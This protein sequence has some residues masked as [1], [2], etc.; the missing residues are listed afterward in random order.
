MRNKS[1]RILFPFMFIISATWGQSYKDIFTLL[2]SK[3]YT[4]A[5]PLL[6]KYIEENKRDANAYLFLGIIF[7][8]KIFTIE[9]QSITIST[10]DSAIFFFDK[11]ISTLSISQIK[12]N[13]KYYQRY[14]RRDLKTGKLGVKYEDII[15][16]LNATKN[17]LNNDLLRLCRSSRNDEVSLKNT[18]SVEA[19]ATSQTQQIKPAGKYFALIIG[20]SEYDN[21]KL[22]LNR[23]VIDAQNFKAAITSLYNFDAENVNLLLNPTRQQILTELFSLRKKLTPKDNLLIFYAGHGM[24]DEE[25]QQG[26]W[27]PRDADSS[28]PSNWLSNNDLREQIR[29][30]KTAHTLLIADAC[31]SGG[32]FRTRG[33]PLIKD[34]SFD[35]LSLYRLPS[36]RAIT[37][38]AMTGVPDQSV[39]FDYLLKGLK[40]NPEKYLTSQVLFD[41]FRLSVINNTLQVPQDGIIAETGDEGGDFVFIKRE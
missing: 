39:F 38:G 40:N 27:W 22:N 5:E 26:Y 23:P 31:F 24:Y 11:A 12:S 8:E 29:G 41:S 10:I 7:Q 30:I 2:E 18:T 37:S 35:I 9:D 32:I 19:P 1:L 36:R 20:V 21:Y 14:K 33:T 34:A 6:K 3:Q 17:S 25:V 13:E 16:D 15:Y 28:S 4:L